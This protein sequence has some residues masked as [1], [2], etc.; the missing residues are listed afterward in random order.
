MCN[1]CGRPGGGRRQEPLLSC[2]EPARDPRLEPNPL[3]N[4]HLE[5]LWSLLR[6]RTVYPREDSS[7]ITS[8]LLELKKQDLS[9][10]LFINPT[11]AAISRAD[12]LVY[13][14][15]RSRC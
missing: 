12:E 1:F 8:K 6:S 14:K 10:L 11:L 2:L 15:P 4:K 5:T 9:S 7:E 3:G 13:I